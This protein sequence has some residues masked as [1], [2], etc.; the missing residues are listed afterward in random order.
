MHKG[1]QLSSGKFVGIFFSSSHRVMHAFIS[2]ALFTAV[3]RE[4][5]VVPHAH[6]QFQNIQ[7]FDI[8]SSCRK[9]YGALKI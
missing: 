3:T 7:S 4:A 5:S 8:F 1:N 9:V 6:I 2:A